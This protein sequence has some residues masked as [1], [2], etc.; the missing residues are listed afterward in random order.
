METRPIIAYHRDNCLLRW[1]NHHVPTHFRPI[2][3]GRPLPGW[4]EATCL[5]TIGLSPQ[6][7]KSM[8]KPPSQLH[9]YYT[10]VYHIN[11]V[12]PT[13]FK[14]CATT[15]IRVPFVW[16]CRLRH[17]G[18]APTCQFSI[19]VP[20]WVNWGHQGLW[21]ALQAI[22]GHNNMSESTEAPTG[23]VAYVVGNFAKLNLPLLTNKFLW[24]RKRTRPV[25]PAQSC[26][27]GLLPISHWMPHTNCH[28]P[29]TS[30]GR[31]KLCASHFA[32]SIYC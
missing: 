31:S 9:N 29:H 8:P 14:E 10:C 26:T 20:L 30:V 2:A 21:G 24:L 12:S 16:T 17:K 19:W 7:H 18:V 4:L 32:H 23:H 3:K 13:R 11:Q 28:A 15:C 1:T 22:S 5:P 27:P 6:P 25:V